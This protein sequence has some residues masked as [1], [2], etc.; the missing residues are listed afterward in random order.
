MM[1]GALPNLAD[2]PQIAKFRKLR[3][4]IL[5]H[6]AA[7]K[8]SKPLHSSGSKVFPLKMSKKEEKKSPLDFVTDE[9]VNNGSPNDQSFNR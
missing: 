8:T 2:L 4:A 6:S 3:S 9:G 1:P 7:S 5:L